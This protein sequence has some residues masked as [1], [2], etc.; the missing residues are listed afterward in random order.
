MKILALACFIMGSFLVSCSNSN[1]SVDYPDAVMFSWD[2]FDKKISLK[3]EEL[4][5]DSLWKASYIYIQDSILFV[6]VL[7]NTQ[8]ALKLYNVK[9]GHKV[10]EYISIGRGPSELIHCTQFQFLED[11]IWAIDMTQNKYLE[12]RR[13]D[14]LPESFEKP[15]ATITLDGI[16][17]IGNPLLIDSSRVI[18]S[19]ASTGGLLTFFDLEKQEADTTIFIPYPKDIDGVDFL[20]RRSFEFRIAANG[21]N[22]YVT[23]LF[24]DLID[25]YSK[26]GVLLKRLFGPDHFI[27][28]MRVVTFGDGAGQMVAPEKGSKAAYSAPV[29]TDDGLMVLYRGKP[30]GPGSDNPNQLF[31]FSLSGHPLIEF[32]L[33]TPIFQF[34][35]DDTVKRIYGLTSTPDFR[36]ICFDYG[37]DI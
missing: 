2:D 10:G 20:K 23:Y 26:S 17:V 27:P 37:A 31:L 15:I 32:E 9:T 18:G 36:V 19:I 22:I 30:I 8:S 33:D 5:L 21:N 29:I 24:T 7:S 11:R 35:V 28:A 1:T 34:C 13:E 4:H 14:S 12:Y 25:I 6:I 3:G 16:S